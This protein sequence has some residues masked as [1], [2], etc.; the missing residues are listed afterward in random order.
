MFALFALSSS[1]H[2]WG[3]SFHHLHGVSTLCFAI[4]APK[5]ILSEEASAVHFLALCA[6][7]FYAA[8]SR[9]EYCAPRLPRGEYSIRLE[10]FG[11]RPSSLGDLSCHRSWENSRAACFSLSFLDML[12]ILPGHFHTTYQPNSSSRY[13][14]Y[15]DDD[16]C[17]STRTC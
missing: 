5:E 12:L 3:K 10:I 4:E 1:F 2:R 17:S 15:Q 9:S 6:F 14:S 16:H 11:R 7:Q 13:E 8:I